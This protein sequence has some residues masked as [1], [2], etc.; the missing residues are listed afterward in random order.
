VTTAQHPGRR[1]RR[2]LLGSI[3]VGLVLLAG[4]AVVLVLLLR[5]GSSSAPP[6]GSLPQA[7]VQQL[8]KALVSQDP[9]TQQS[10]LDPAV[11][12]G[13]QQTGQ[14]LLPAGSTLTIDP[15]TARVEGHAATVSATV[16]G[17]RSGR[18]TL[19]LALENG[20]WVVF[21]ADPS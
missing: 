9:A 16:K 2:L 15:S 20:T 17:P 8:Q 18:F 3:A 10:A 21:A 5:S 14:P 4:V 11:Y 7:R 13:L 12:A 1:T 19:Q 6:H